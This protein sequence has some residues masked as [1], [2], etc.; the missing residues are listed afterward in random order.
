MEIKESIEFF[1]ENGFGFAIDRIGGEKKVAHIYKLDENNEFQEPLCPKGWNRGKYGYSILRFN[2]SPK[3][4]CK[5]CLKKM[6]E[7]LESRG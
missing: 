5:D 7:E 4:L 3:G 2:S 1:R 6:K